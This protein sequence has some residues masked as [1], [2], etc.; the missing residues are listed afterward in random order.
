MLEYSIPVFESFHKKRT[1][2]KLGGLIFHATN[3]VSV[4]EIDQEEVEAYVSL[5]MKITIQNNK[6]MRL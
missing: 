6:K 4:V 2:K 1:H 5:P 3:T